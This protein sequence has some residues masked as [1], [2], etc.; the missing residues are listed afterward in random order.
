ML[1]RL[2]ELIRLE[3]EAIVL[4]PG[5]P[6]GSEIVGGADRPSPPSFVQGVSFN[7]LWKF[8]R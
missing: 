4:P 5:E 7:D 1:T 2:D 6:G 8:L 3:G